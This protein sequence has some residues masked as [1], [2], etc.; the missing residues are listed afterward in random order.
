MLDIVVSGGLAVL[1]SGPEPADIGVAGERIVAI[2]A[3]GSLTAVGAGRVVDATGQIVI[4]GGIDPHVHCRWPIVVPGRGEHQLTD[5]AEV[6][7]RAALFG[8]TTTIIDFAL[9]ETGDDVRSAI[10]RRQKEW[11]GAC[12]C[13]YAFHTM[14]QGKIAPEILPQLVEAVEAGHPSVK[15]FTTD[16]TPSRKGRMVDFGDIWEVLKVL[17][18]AGG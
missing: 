3:P 14:V 7:S 17:A 9:V 4:P 8:G 5:P 1:S 10:E 18:Q 16:I 15:I 6:V 12:H 11:A 13:D 2:G